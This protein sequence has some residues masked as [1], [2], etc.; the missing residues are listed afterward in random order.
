MVAPLVVHVV[1]KFGCH[2]FI[3]G[4]LYQNENIAAGD[5]CHY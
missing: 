2:G 3:G 4:Y 5:F 1:L